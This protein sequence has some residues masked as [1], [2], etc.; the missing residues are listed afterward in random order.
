MTDISSPRGMTSLGLGRVNP[1]GLMWFIALMVVAIPIFWLGMKSLGAAWITPE[2]SHGPLIPVL[3]TL[4]FLRELRDERAAACRTRGRKGPPKRSDSVA[5]MGLR[6]RALLDRFQES[7]RRPLRLDHGVLFLPTRGA[8]D[9]LAAGAPDDGGAS[10]IR[11]A[12]AS[13]S[14]RGNSGLATLSRS[15]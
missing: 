10:A 2:Y 12:D 1:V 6:A 8:S 9:L 3:S 14:G 5:R 11:R 4:L 15:C 7:T 13:C